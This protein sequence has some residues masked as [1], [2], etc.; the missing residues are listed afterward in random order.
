MEEENEFN[1]SAFKIKLEVAKTKVSPRLDLILTGCPATSQA[2]K[3][4]PYTHEAQLTLYVIHNIC[5]S[6]GYDLKY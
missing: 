2:E 6:I 4:G 5:V 1:L 3:G